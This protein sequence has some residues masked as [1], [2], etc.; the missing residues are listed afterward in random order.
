MISRRLSLAVLT[1]AAILSLGA[2][3]SKKVERA[4]RSSTPVVVVKT[5][6]G[7]FR[8][9]LDRARAPVTVDN[10]LRYVKARFYDGTIFHRVIPG[11]M[12]QGGG[13]T[14]DLVQKP[15]RDPIVNESANGLSNVVGTVAM[16]RRPD[17]DSATSQFFI[18]VADNRRLDARDG[19]PGYTVFGKVV[20]GMDVVQ[21]IASV[22]TGQ[23]GAMRDVPL[24]PVVIESIRLAK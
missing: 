2:A 22:P 7:T 9:E 5:S 10:F 15:T 17:P 12:I 1:L 23:K 21:A 18:N 24:E 6:K 16:A 3:G 4:R 8:I 11:F 13:F 19:Q 20:D 14:P